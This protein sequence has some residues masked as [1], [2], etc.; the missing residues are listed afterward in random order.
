MTQ[1][2]WLVTGCSTGFG[3][4][5]IKNILQRGDKAIATARN[6]DSLKELASLGAAT[7][8]LDVTAPLS[9]LREKVEQAIEIYGHI[10]VL[11]ANAGYAQTGCVEELR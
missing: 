7:L 10:D 6:V 8:Q 2:V 11:I 9:E 3:K 5:F 4:E 1:L